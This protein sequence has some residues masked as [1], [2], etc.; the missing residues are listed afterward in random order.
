MVL[1]LEQKFSNCG[2]FLGREDDELDRDIMS[3]LYKTTIENHEYFEKSIKDKIK[4]SSSLSKTYAEIVL[5]PEI[6]LKRIRDLGISGHRAFQHLKENPEPIED[7]N[8]D[9]FM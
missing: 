3:I 9:D 6:I 1:E 5:F 7:V 2:Y 8:F 4:N